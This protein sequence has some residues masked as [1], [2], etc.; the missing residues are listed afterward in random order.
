MGNETIFVIEDER[1]IRELILFNLSREGYRVRDFASAEPALESLKSEKP[2]MILLDMMLPGI[3]GFET[4]RRIRMNGDTAAVPVIMVTARTDDADIVAALELGADDYICKPFSP[5]VLTARIRTRLRERQR[6]QSSAG[7]KTG[8][9]SVSDEEEKILSAHGITLDPGRHETKL[10]GAV[11][12]LSATEFSFLAFFLANPGRVFSRQRLID[13]VHGNGYS[14]TDRSVDVQILSLR[15]KLC[16]VG[17]CIET[18]RGVG[19]R[20][21]EDPQA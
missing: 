2:D 5:R 8:S 4:L 10:D 9:G 14:V 12:D 19:Y 3:D 1:D 17:D 11:L 20:F 21:R 6:M 18:V 7:G 15:K 16:P 13:A